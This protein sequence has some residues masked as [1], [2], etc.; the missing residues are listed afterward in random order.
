M[1][2]RSLKDPS[3]KTV[4][5]RDQNGPSRGKTDNSRLTADT[6]PPKCGAKHGSSEKSSGPYTNTNSRAG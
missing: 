6:K 1:G 4:P 5:V 2:Y 3:V